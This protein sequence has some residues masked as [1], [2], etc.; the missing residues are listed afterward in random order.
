MLY[1]TIKKAT[2]YDRMKKQIPIKK[3]MLK[4]TIILFMFKER[5]SNIISLTA[6]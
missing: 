4:D 3:I 1:Y 6:L 5:K 2:F